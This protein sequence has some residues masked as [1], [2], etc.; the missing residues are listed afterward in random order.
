M[1][2]FCDIFLSPFLFGVGPFVD[3]IIALKTG[4]VNM[5]NAPKFSAII[6][7]NCTLV[8]SA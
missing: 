4:A 1:I 5:A 3:Y 7:S 6:C 2:S 8:F